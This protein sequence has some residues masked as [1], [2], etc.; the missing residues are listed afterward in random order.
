MY[1]KVCLEEYED[2]KEYGSV[3]VSHLS[4]VVENVEKAFL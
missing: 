2:V 1:C 4:V 3:A